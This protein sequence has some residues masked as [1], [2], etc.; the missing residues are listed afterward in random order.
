MSKILIYISHPAQFHF[1]KNIIR[2]LKEDGGEVMVLIKTKDI[3]E[4]LVKEEGLDYIN[5]QS[6]PR[7]NNALSMVWAQLKRTAKVLQL[8][9]KFRPSLM[10]GTDASVAQAAKCLRVPA[11]TTLEDDVEVI[12]RLAKLTYPFTTD[13]MVPTCC[14]VGK[15]EAKKIAYEGYM[16]LAYLHPNY[17]QPDIHLIKQYIPEE[18]YVLM[19]LAKLTAHHDAGQKE[20][21]A[22][23]LQKLIGMMETHGYS[24]YI[25][26]E[27]AIPP[28]LEKYV[29][30]IDVKNIHHV[31]SG[32]A[33][34]I[35]DSQSMSMEAAMLGTPS[36]RFSNFAGKISVLEELE[37]N[38]GLTYGI[39]ADCPQLLYEKVES[40]MLQPDLKADFRLRR[41]RMLKDKIDVTAFFSWF[42]ENYPESRQKIKET[43]DFQY[44]FK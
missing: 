14:R 7:K 33:L 3:L 44:R 23:V 35:S 18:K 31:L 5:I 27:G 6:E 43:P 34:L 21:E 20:I 25:S 10:M 8:A 30:H 13:I 39:K 12:P 9:K 28:A 26:A 24:V 2:R 36:V 32:A 17:F 15:W 37:N 40:L 16:K 41:E 19:R 29:L 11:I 4:S 22:E 42:I 38:Y 1:F